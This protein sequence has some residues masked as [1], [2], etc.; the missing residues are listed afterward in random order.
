MIIHCFTYTREHL[1]K[2]SIEGYIVEAF[3]E[4]TRILMLPCCQT[5]CRKGHCFLPFIICL[6]VSWW[7]EIGFEGMSKWLPLWLKVGSKDILLFKLGF[8]KCFIFIAHILKSLQNTTRDNSTPAYVNSC[9]I[10]TSSLYLHFVSKHLWV[11]IVWD[12]SFYFAVVQYEFWLLLSKLIFT[13][14]K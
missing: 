12:S 11:M 9:P 8:P 4:Q 5:Y 13:V 2:H 7:K 10:F 6:W 3:F 14:T 1:L